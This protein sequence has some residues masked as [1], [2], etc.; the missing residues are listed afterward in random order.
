ML[1]SDSAFSSQQPEPVLTA[2]AFTRG[3]RC[4]K[5]LSLATHRPELVASASEQ[6]DSFRERKRDV[7]LLAQQLFPEGVDV[8]R[9]EGESVRDAVARTSAA[10]VGGAPTL[11][12]ASVLHESVLATVDILERDGEEW[13]I[14]AIIAA[15]KPNPQQLDELAFQHHILS[16]AG[17]PVSDIGLIQ[18]DTSYV[19][20]GEL[21]PQ[22][23]FNRVSILA[24]VTSRQPAATANLPAMLHT[25][26]S[27]DIPDIATG[28]HCDQP[29][30][31]DFKGHCWAGTATTAPGTG[32]RVDRPRLRQYL[33]EFRYPLHFLDFETFS[34]PIP[35]FEGS[36]PFE[37][38]P[39]Q[40][41][42][43]RQETRNGPVSHL[44]FLASGD[45]DPRQPLVAALLD[46][47]GSEG[48]V[49]A[50]HL[51]FEVGVL[52]ALARWFPEHRA[53]LEAI[54]A[55]GKDLID[56]F[57]QQWYDDFSKGRSNSIKAVLPAL[58]PGF[59]YADLPVRDGLTA[60]R[61]FY[62]LVRGRY[63]GDP[64]QLRNDLLA[65]CALDTDA[66]VRI[67]EVL[68]AASDSQ[69]Q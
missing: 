25:L 9:T 5:A 27:A 13:R 36:R 32:R 38:I 60:S 6:A 10:I 49:L 7:A 66:M 55:R 40:F 51:P 11:F 52:E 53:R 22:L 21:D 34:S 33:E 59:S 26:A 67:L 15:T 17:L 69:A 23:L 57:K 24:K 37:Q 58:V 56:P 62:D 29:H 46:A 31:C 64:D 61:L 48:T 54:V 35:L 68:D 12:G 45:G 47:I 2:S 39:F 3:Q 50:Y 41:S 42:I 14:I 65:Y 20:Q 1:T 16:A 28:K 19:R 63:A 8:R 4:L 44:P 30:P 18:V 43:R